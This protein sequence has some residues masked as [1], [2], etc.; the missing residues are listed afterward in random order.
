MLT[1][2]AAVLAYDRERETCDRRSSR[3]RLRYVRSETSEEN[4][5]VAGVGIEG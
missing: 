5:M 2:V 1:L 3:S 4:D